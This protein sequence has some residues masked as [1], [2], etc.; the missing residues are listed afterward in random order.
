MARVALV[1]EPNLTYFVAKRANFVR[2]G[3]HG[4]MLPRA[5]PS[6]S[7]AARSCTANA[8]GAPLAKAPHG[9]PSARRRQAAVAPGTARAIVAGDIYILGAF[10]TP[11]AS[12]LRSIQPAVL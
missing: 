1:P 12:Q 5:R 7:T 9:A 10:D 2:L 8:L 4:R 6:A 11:D 3:A